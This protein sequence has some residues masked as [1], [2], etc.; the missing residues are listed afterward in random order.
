MNPDKPVNASNVP[1]GQPQRQ[2]TREQIARRAEQIWRQRNQPTGSDEAIW[3]QAE[4]ELQAEAESRPVT[5]TPSRP[6][7]NEPGSQLRSRTKVQDPTDSAVQTR[8]ETK[9]TPRK[10]TKQ[11]RNQ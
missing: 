1:T 3:L 9:A 4:S 8:S 5:G 7:E 2:V 11:I 6:L 10:K